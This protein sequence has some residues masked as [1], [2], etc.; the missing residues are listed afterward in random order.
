MSIPADAAKVDAAP[1]DK[2]YTTQLSY[3]YG[4]DQFY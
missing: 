2:L 3:H 1:A 4:H